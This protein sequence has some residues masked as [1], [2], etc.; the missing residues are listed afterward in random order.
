MSSLQEYQDAVFEENF[1]YIASILWNDLFYIDWSNSW[2][3][4]EYYND[5]GH[6]KKFNKYMIDFFGNVK[7]IRKNN[8]VSPILSGYYHNIGLFDHNDKRHN[9]SVHRS[10][11]ST[12]Y[13]K[14]STLDHS[15]DHIYSAQKTNNSIWNLKWSTYSEQSMNRENPDD[16]KS[17]FVIVKD[18][19]EKTIKEWMAYMS[20]SETTI[21]NKVQNNI[22]GFSYKIYEDLPGEYWKIIPNSI[23]YRGY[24]MIS[25]KSRVAIHNNYGARHIRDAQVLHKWGKYPKVG[26]MFA[27]QIIM[28]LFC[29]EK[30]KYKKDGEI[31]L[32]KNDNKLD[33]SP[34]N[35]YFG[36]YPQNGIDAHDNGSFDGTLTERKSCV[37]R[38]LDG[39]LVKRFDSRADA[40]DW[41]I[42]QGFEKAIRASITMVIDKF[43]KDGITRKLSCSYAWTSM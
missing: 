31:I 39:T 14:P 27:H 13:G 18:G 17:A 2:Q 35:L 9:I 25:N 37:A 20:C 11:C 32:H 5:D 42:S 43:R 22:D 15:A 29:P 28:E 7:H 40:A 33:F 36:S 41:L 1:I 19:I 23:I 30:I 3:L 16:R 21:Y 12:I 8:I 38:L 6:R 10:I 4:L 26:D 24:M 34:E